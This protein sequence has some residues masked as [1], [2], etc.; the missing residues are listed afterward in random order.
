MSSKDFNNICFYCTLRIQRVDVIDSSK[1]MMRRFFFFVTLD[2]VT[3]NWSWVK[4]SRTRISTSTC[5]KDCLWDLLIVMTNVD[6]MKYCRLM[7]KHDTFLLRFLLLSS[8]FD[9]KEIWDINILMSACF[10][11]ITFVFKT[12][13][14]IWVSRARVSLHITRDFRFRMIMID[15]S[16]LRR[17]TWEDNEISS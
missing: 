2:I 7:K 9:C 3:Y 1:T 6:R 5:L 4:I 12:F 8:S 14:S 13:L 10:S 16:I 17:S 15:M 11:S